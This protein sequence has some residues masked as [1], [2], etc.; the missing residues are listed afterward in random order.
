[1]PVINELKP[2]EK[3]LKTLL[4]R[5]AAA[6][7]FIVIVTPHIGCY[8]RA[9]PGRG[10]IEREGEVSKN[11]SKSGNQSKSSRAG[12]KNGREGERQSRR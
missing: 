7:T 12:R 8:P 3:S 6:K 2:S 5:L 4:R 1:M 11:R 10:R 9:S